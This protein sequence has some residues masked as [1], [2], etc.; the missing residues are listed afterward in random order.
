M[1]EKARTALVTGA[2]RGIG[3]AIAIEQAKRNRDIVIADLNQEEMAETK[4]QIEE[5]GQ[6]AL[7]LHTDIRDDRSIAE[8]VDKAQEAFGSIDVLVNNSGISGPTLPCDDMPIEE[9]DETIAVNL[10]G[11]FLMCRAVLPIMKRQEFG[12]IV[13]IASVTGKRPVPERTP[14]AAS[15]MGLIGF[16]RSLAA[17][18]GDRDI[19]VNVVCPGSVK[20]PRIERVFRR[21]AEAEGV[22]SQEVKEREMDRSARNEL[23]DRQNVARVV[24]FLSSDDASQMTGQDLNVSA[25][26]VMY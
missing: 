24:A 23:V 8:T 14:Y 7:C 13:N 3:Q 19:N 6:R 12:R 4:E 10:R 2:G 25:G 9:W 5:L 1:G 17:E 26:K 18:V 15:K 21:H 22:T 16:T 20:G 11:A